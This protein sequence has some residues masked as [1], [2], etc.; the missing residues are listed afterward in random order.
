MSTNPLNMDLSLRSVFI[1][2]TIEA[3]RKYLDVTEAQMEECFHL[4]CCTLE[5][6][7]PTDM[8]EETYDEHLREHRE[9]RDLY[10]LDLR[11][12]LR[13][14]LL[15]LLHIV[16][17]THLRIFCNDIKSQRGLPNIAMKD[18]RGSAIDQ[19]LIFLTKL[20]NLKVQDFPEWEHLRTLQKM[21]NCIVHCFGHVDDSTDG[22]FL[23][24][25]ASRGVGVS[26]EG[27]EGRLSVTKQFC[28]QQLAHLLSLFER[29][30]TAA[31]WS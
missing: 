9:L 15:M 24:E 10:D 4:E 17:E 23:R 14:S 28:E 31:G 13:Y 11:P 20:A 21:R 16:F 25:L 22:R 7:A 26:I 18:L 27:P 6:E 29:L 8:D 12:S 19:G 30:F 3:L 1:P 2:S 5:T